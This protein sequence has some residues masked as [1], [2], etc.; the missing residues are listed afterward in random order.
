MKYQQKA[1]HAFLAAMAVWPPA[2]IPNAAPPPAAP[3]ATFVAKAPTAAPPTTAPQAKFNPITPT[4]RSNPCDSGLCPVPTFTISPIPCEYLPSFICPRPADGVYL[5]LGDSLALGLY[6]LP[7]YADIFEDYIE[8]TAGIELDSRNLARSGWHSSQLAAALQ[9]DPLFRKQIAKADVITWNIGGNDLRIARDLFHQGRCGGED[10]QQCLRHAVTAFRN[11]WNVII[12][13]LQA[14]RKSQQS[15]IRT[16]NLYNPYVKEDM[17]RGTFAVLD[18][19]FDQANTHIASS[20]IRTD[21]SL[22]PISIAFNGPRGLEDPAD[23]GFIAFDGYHPNAAGHRVIAKQ[24]I[25]LGLPS[26]P[27]AKVS[28]IVFPLTTPG[29]IP[30]PTPHPTPFLLPLPTPPCTGICPL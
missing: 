24:L 26:L 3:I 9:H 17:A 5:I 2:F 15:T 20:L 21:I 6:G 1:R 29:L 18:P 4:P 13:E 11:N 12:S 19:Y 30:M 8:D 28:P 25:Q 16:M 14:L 10:N 27:R 23:K 22:A 7:G